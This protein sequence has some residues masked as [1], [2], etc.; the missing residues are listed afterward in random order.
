[1]TTTITPD[2]DDLLTPVALA[3]P[4]AVCGLPLAHDPA[5]TP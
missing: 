4:Y 3:D 5:G 1:M 2:H